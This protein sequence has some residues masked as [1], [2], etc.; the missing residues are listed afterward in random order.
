MGTDISR[1]R[2]LAVDDHPIVREGIAGLLGVQPDMILVCEASNGRDAI[3]QFRAHHPDITL[4]DLQMPEIERNVGIDPVCDPYVKDLVQIIAR[5][6]A[7]EQVEALL[8]PL[9]RRLQAA[10][11]PL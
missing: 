11:A 6:F 3:Q 4:M 9:Q 8:P 1:I 10:M 7:E 2:V 5:L